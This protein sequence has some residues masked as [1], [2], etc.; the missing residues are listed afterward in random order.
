[1][2]SVEYHQN[3]FRCLHRAP[4][5][6]IEHILKLDKRTVPDIRSITTKV[7]HYFTSNRLAAHAKENGP[8]SGGCP[9]SS[10]I[11]VNIHGQHLYRELN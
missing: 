6:N 9:I 1:M 3:V 11:M 2:T 8:V 7:D 4:T 5:Q 10:T